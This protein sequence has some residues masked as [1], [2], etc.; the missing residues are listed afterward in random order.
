MYD[1]IEERM[2]FDYNDVWEKYDGTLKL[3]LY[4]TQNDDTSLFRKSDIYSSSTIKKAR[5]HKIRHTIVRQLIPKY[6][7]PK[8]MFK[9]VVDKTLEYSK[10]DSQMYKILINMM[11]GMLAKTKCYK[12]NIKLIPIKTKYLHFF[13]SIPI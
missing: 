4:Y 13:V 8:N 3:G 10:G 1:P 2:R 6:T 9:L 12:V 7:E 5:K 11:S